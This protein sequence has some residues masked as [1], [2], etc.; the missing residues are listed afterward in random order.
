MNELI[1]LENVRFYLCFGIIVV[2]TVLKESFT[3][4]ATACLTG[5]KFNFWIP[6]EAKVLLSRES[7]Y[8]YNFILQ[9]VEE[10]GGVL[11]II[12]P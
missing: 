6:G 7:V 2:T 4:D 5:C 12:T 9:I 10:F 11:N 3:V 1:L 8:P